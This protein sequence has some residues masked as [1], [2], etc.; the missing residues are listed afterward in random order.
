MRTFSEK[1]EG[2]NF[3]R[4]SI[5]RILWTAPNESDVSVSPSERGNPMRTIRTLLVRMRKRHN[6]QKIIKNLA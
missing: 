2:V 3:S 6:F 5:G 1:K 4:F